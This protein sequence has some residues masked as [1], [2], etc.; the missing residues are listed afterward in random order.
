VKDEKGMGQVKL[1][2]EQSYYYYYYYYTFVSG[3]IFLS[4]LYNCS[5]CNKGFC[6][7]HYMSG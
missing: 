7:L 4:E 6:S 3:V 1:V 2:S 5:Y